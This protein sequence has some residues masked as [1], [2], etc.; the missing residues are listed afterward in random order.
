MIRR[1]TWVIIIVFVL[2]I[3]LAVLVEKTPYFQ[4]ASTPTATSA[5]SLLKIPSGGINAIKL[6][7][8]Q[9]PTISVKL[10][11]GGGWV[12]DQPL[13]AMPDQANMAEVT[14]TLSTLQILVAPATSIPEAAAGLQS[15]A[16]TITILSGTNQQNVLKIGNS[17]PTSSGYY[18]QLD[19]NKPVIVDKGTIDRV[20][21]LLTGIGATPTAPPQPSPATTVTPETPVPTATP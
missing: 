5:P 18:V 6:E 4:P 14:T 21:Q 15:P 7:V 3:G 11:G 17:T 13:N 8:L 20:I 2:V 9:G 1:S 19:Q 16:Q 12:A 10:I